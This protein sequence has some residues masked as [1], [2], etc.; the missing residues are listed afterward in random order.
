MSTAL[1]VYQPGL[2]GTL[3]NRVGLLRQ[4]QGTL[5][6]L[7]AE[8]ALTVRRVRDF[9]LRFKPAVGD[10]HE[11]LERLRSR[12]ARAWEAVARARGGALPGARD[13]SPNDD[14]EATGPA[15]V[16]EADGMGASDDAARLLFL[17]L[18]RQVHPDFAED[19]DE[20]RRRHEVMSEATLA[21]RNNDDRRLQWLIEHWQTQC[22]PILGIG[23]ATL[24]RRTN[25]QIAWVRYRIR[26]VQHSLAQLHASSTAHIMEREAQ[27]RLSGINLIVEMRKRAIADLEAAYRD[28][29][30]VQR[31]VEDLDP[32]TRRAIK[33]EC[34]L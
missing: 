15:G 20:R 5:G 3:F 16:F 34:D 13:G 28:L 8:Y 9:E 25:R 23:P 26:E 22:E 18:A 24:W 6:E 14:P 31:A 21:Y 29:D 12:V 1:V 30:R 2:D 33:T 10:R 27:A 32:R 7:E 19:P 11:E 17:A 4:L